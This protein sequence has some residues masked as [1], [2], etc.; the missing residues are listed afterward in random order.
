MGRTFDRR[1]R[2]HWND[3]AHHQ[4]I[5]EHLNSGQVLL[6]RLRRAWVLFD[7]GR[8]VHRRDQPNVVKMLLGPR[9]KLSAGPCVSFAGVQVPDPGCEKL[10]ELGS[11]VFA[12]VGQNGRYG[13]GVAEDG[14]YA[15]RI[16]FEF[17]IV[18][19][20]YDDPFVQRSCNAVATA[21]RFPESN[22]ATAGTLPYLATVAA[23]A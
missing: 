11:G 15:S 10:E 2:V 3:L 18:V 7:I 5:K 6:D 19:P 17:M 9:Q 4:V 20:G 12:R 16:V 8:D 23:V 21:S 1:R 13:M 14:L 22:A